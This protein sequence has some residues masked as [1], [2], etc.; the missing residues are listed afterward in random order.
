MKGKPWIGM[1]ELFEIQWILSLI[2]HFVL[3]RDRSLMLNN[4]TIT[5]KSDLAF[6]FM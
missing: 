3:N 4:I 5:P 2:L 6:V 1:N